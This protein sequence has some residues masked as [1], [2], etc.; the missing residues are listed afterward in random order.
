V[1]GSNSIGVGSLVERRMRAASRRGRW[2]RK[3]GASYAGASCPFSRLCPRSFR[4][5]ARP[6]GA[7]L[8]DHAAEHGYGLAAFNVNN[9]EQIQGDHGGGEGDRQ[10]GH[11][12]GL[13]PA[14]RSYSQDNYLRHP[15]LAAAELYPKIPIAMH[16]DH[17]NSP[18]T[19][20]SAID[21][22][23]TSVMMDGSLKEE[24]QD[25]GRLRLQRESH[26]GSRAQLAHRQGVS[27]E[28]ELGCLG[29]LESR[30]GEA[31]DGHGRHSASVPPLRASHG[32]P[33]EA[34][35]FVAA[36]GVDWR[37]PWPSALGQPALQAHP[38]ARWRRA[39]HEADRGDPP[40]TAE[41]PS[42]DA[43]LI[44][45]AAGSA[46]HHQQ[47]RRHDAADLGRA[48]R[49][50]PEG[51]R[52]WRAE[53]Q[54]RHRLPHGD[55]RRDPQGA[56]RDAREVRPARL[57][58]AVARGDEEGVCRANACKSGQAGNAGKVERIT[59]ADMAA[60]YAKG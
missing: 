47:V 3:T 24:R 21:N 9:M 54:R 55:H 19:C 7:Y 48:R 22:G 58:E 52:A 44:E 20:Q 2:R 12:A 35:R 59:L 1:V 10:P 51:H 23:F 49:G 50:N 56:L 5:A 46:R 17:G 41:L 29:S 15:M 36:T 34:A 11:R 14:A 45:R 37:R 28:G 33:D 32:I 38:Q 13:P 25:A 8:L 16:Q 27:V 18:S 30:E 53:D 40:Q 39:R 60:K 4:H 42:R 6:H 31:E 57:P 43:W 26:E